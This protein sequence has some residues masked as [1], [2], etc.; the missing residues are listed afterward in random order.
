MCHRGV[1]P[2]GCGLSP[3]KTG[4]EETEAVQAASAT[5]YSE[6]YTKRHDQNCLPPVLIMSDNRYYVKPSEALSTLQGAALRHYWLISRPFSLLPVSICFKS[7]RKRSSA[8][9]RSAVASSISFLA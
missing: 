4:T 5:F 7:V 1:P 3:R 6:K 2:V 9:S 8:A